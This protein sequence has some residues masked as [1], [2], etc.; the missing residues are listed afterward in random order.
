MKN[1]GTPSQRKIIL[2]KILENSIN[3]NESILD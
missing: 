2:E 3:P 1:F